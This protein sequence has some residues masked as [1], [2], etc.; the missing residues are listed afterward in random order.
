MALVYVVTSSQGLRHTQKS[1]NRERK[2]Y[3]FCC[4]FVVG[5]FKTR[6]S[7]MAKWRNDEM[8]KWN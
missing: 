3:F 4:I 2:L 8:A 6:N 5:V 7:E 1:R